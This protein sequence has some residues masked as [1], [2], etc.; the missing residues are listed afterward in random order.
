MNVGD[1]STKSK[2]RFPQNKDGKPKAK[3]SVVDKL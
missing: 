3:G 2:S 1:P